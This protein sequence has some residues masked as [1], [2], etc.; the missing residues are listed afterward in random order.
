MRAVIQRVSK[1][2]VQVDGEIIS[3]IGNGLLI[4]LGIEESDGQEDIEW[5]SKKIVNLR[6][7][8]DE[9]KVM[10]ESVVQ[11]NGDIIVVS[12]FTLHALIK[13]G[14]RPS[15]INAAKP[16][17]AI[18]LYK[19]F[20]LQQ[21]KDLGKKVGTGV[22]GADMKVELLNDGPVTILIDTKNRE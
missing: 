17:I 6:I 19:R 21:E 14:N 3:K 20:V 15:Y 5:L 8:N 9:N 22:F 13:K 1:A 7:F 10:N 18:P 2:S 16:D 4:L 12:Q 11:Q